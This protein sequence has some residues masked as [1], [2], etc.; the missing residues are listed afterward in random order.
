MMTAR[1]PE[2]EL[3]NQLCFALYDASRA[4]V[5]AYGPLLG[6]LGL[7]YPQYVTM[8]VLW[9]TDGPISMGDLGARLHLE[10]GT[11]TPLIKRL[12]Q[13]GLVERRRDTEDERRVLIEVT[14]Q[15][16]ELRQRAR[17]VP[18]RIFGQF[19]LDIDSARALRDQLSV[20]VTTLEGGTPGG[21]E[22]SAPR[23]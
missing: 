22:A 11:L 16:A 12:G 17:E 19:G 10:S 6:E 2:L 23:G 20:L 13:L 4:V 15:G 7:T 3:D 9:E 1:M 5:R 14:Q 18:P 8:L 21:S